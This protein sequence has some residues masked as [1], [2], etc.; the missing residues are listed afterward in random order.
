MAFAFLL[1]AIAQAK[2]VFRDYRQGVSRF[3][4]VQFVERNGYQIAR[5]ERP[6]LYWY[7]FVWNALIAIAAS[8][9]AA[10]FAQMA[11]AGI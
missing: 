1:V 9:G 6:K 8:A 5:A 10:M 3:Y 11:I 2:L 4:F 7:S